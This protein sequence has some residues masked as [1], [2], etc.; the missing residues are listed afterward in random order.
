MRTAEITGTKMLRLLF[1]L[2]IAS[3]EAFSMPADA[4]FCKNPAETRAFVTGLYSRN[5][6]ALLKTVSSR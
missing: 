3:V 5:T 6:T 4:R 1:A 2:A